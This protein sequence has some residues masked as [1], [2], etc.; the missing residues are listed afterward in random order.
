MI[1]VEYDNNISDLNVKICEALKDDP[2]QQAM[3]EYET[4]DLVGEEYLSVARKFVRIILKSHCQNRLCSSC[5]G[6]HFE[7]ADDD[8]QVCTKCFVVRYSLAPAYNNYVHFP[9]KNEYNKRAYF[10]KCLVKLLEEISLNV[11][12]QIIDMIL[13]DYDN[14]NDDFEKS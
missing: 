7:V 2:F 5:G 6:K 11:P 1:Y 3:Y 13:D 8:G 4:Q 14:L 10:E 12:P 9:S